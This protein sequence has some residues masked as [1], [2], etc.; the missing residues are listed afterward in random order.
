MLSRAYTKRLTSKKVS[1]VRKL[2]E[3]TV[4]GI[5]EER[6]AHTFAGNLGIRCESC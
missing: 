6:I 1:Q 5:T 3:C 2:Q 4:V